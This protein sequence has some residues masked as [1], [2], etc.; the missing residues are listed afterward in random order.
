MRPRTAARAPQQL[1]CGRHAQVCSGLALRVPVLARLESAG[2]GGGS[3]IEG[4]EGGVC[5]EQGEETAG[6]SWWGLGIVFSAL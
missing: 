5:V 6:E 3:G 1:A 4:G 2:F